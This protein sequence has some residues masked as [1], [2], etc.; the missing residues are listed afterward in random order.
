MFFGFFVGRFRGGGF[1]V[2]FSFDV[3]VIGCFKFFVG[4]FRC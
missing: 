2:V 1:G 3:L 4:V